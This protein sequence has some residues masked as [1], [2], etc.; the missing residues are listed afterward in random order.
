MI[1]PRTTQFL[2]AALLAT[3]APALSADKKD[4][5]QNAS[6][7]TVKLVEYFLKVPTADANPELINPF[8]AVNVESLPK[9]MRGKAAAKQAEVSALIR[10]HDRRK[11]GSL[12]QPKEDC[13]MKDF[14]K[15]LNM[16]GFF[17]S[18]EEVTED[19]LRY[20]SDKT[21]C[22]EMDLG[23]RFSLLIFYEKKK[24]RILKFMPNDPIM[25]IVAEFRNKGGSTNFF[26]SGYTCM[27]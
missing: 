4:V 11:A 6:E 25:A 17:G 15:P 22:T 2:M 9:K 3:A 21:K 26:G 18:Y 1:A 19:E 13:S 12:V 5:D 14:I 24:D 8:L 23:C 16:A 7:T 20:V 27:H 10:L